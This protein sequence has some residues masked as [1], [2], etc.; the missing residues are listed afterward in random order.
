[1]SR[2]HHVRWQHTRQAV[3]FGGK[4]LRDSPTNDIKVFSRNKTRTIWIIRFANMANDGYNIVSTLF[5]QVY[6]TDQI[7]Q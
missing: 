6:V 7:I 4:T 2:Y 3:I 1:M 5:F